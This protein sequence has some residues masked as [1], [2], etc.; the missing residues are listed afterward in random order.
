MCIALPMR[1]VDVVDPGKSLV[2]VEP[3][4]GVAAD[5]GGND[6]VS[7]ALVADDATAL[8]ALV[9]RW[10]L[11]HAGFLMEIIEEDDALERLA[12]FAAMD[13]ADGDF[14]GI[15]FDEVTNATL[16]QA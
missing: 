1:V 15:D 11:I 5:R 16:P 3:G 6:I 10:G 7:A 14:P 9:G 4:P 8:V 12:V 2:A 13:G